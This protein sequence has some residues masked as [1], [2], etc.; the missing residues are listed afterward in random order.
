H[1]STERVR[2]ENVVP[3]PVHIR[4]QR[5][6]LSI[7]L[8]DFLGS[9]WMVRFAGDPRVFSHCTERA[10]DDAPARHPMCPFSGSSSDRLKLH[11]GGLLPDARDVSIRSTSHLWTCC[12]ESQSFCCSVGS[13][14]RP[15]RRTCSISA[16]IRVRYWDTSVR[17]GYS[18][19]GLRQISHKNHILALKRWRASIFIGLPYSFQFTMRAAAR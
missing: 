2:I 19:A 8:A 9:S 6:D 17:M 13:S 5:D 15:A 1:R 4:T 18:A 14:A 16:G 3:E 10:L 12:D 11:A 7:C